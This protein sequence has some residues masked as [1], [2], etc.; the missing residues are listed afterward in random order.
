M[1]QDNER[2]IDY[3]LAAKETDDEQVGMATDYD[4]IGTLVYPYLPLRMG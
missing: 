3:V 1:F 2:R 4:V